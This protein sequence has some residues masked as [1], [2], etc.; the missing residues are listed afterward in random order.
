MKRHGNRGFTLIEMLIVVGIIAV[1]VAVSIPMVNSSLE[2]ARIATDMANER[3]AKAAA[4]IM[5]L[6]GDLDGFIKKQYEFDYI[7]IPY[8]AASGKLMLNE[9]KDGVV[10]GAMP[11]YGKCKDHRDMHIKVS[12]KPKTDGVDVT[13]R[14]YGDSAPL[15]AHGIDPN[16]EIVRDIPK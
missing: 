8:D 11:E 13:V 7:E 3:A 10:T 12:I 6:N 15:S 9:T 1:L 5:Y 16:K 14:W 2:K 4:T